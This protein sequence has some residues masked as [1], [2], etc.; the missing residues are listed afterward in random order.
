[1]TTCSLG[2]IGSL[3]YNLYFNAADVSKENANFAC[4]MMSSDNLPQISQTS[5]ISKTNCISKT[6]DK[7]HTRGMEML[8]KATFSHMCHG[9]CLRIFKVSYI[10][11]QELSTIFINN[12]FF[13]IPVAQLNFFV[14][15]FC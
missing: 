8:K 4:D 3:E 5:T 10:F 11:W 13:F 14:K 15:R 2:A 7:Y 6:C 12:K 1:M 9:V